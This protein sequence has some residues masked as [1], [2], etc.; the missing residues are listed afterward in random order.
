VTDELVNLNALWFTYWKRHVD[1]VRV[2]ILYALGEHDWL[3]HGDR[4]IRKTLWGLSPR[5]RVEGIVAGGPHALERW[6]SSKG[7]YARCFG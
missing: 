7:W 4:S 2:P 1:E 5:V 6:W 3:W